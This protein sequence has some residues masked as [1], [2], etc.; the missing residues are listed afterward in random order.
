MESDDQIIESLILNGGLEVYAIDINTGEALYTFT[1]KLEQVNPELH[2]AAKNYF[3]LE[4]INLWEK[5]FL[6]IDLESDDPVVS[7]TDKAL[8]ENERESLDKYSKQSL[9]QVMKATNK[10]K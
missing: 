1:D 7:V 3:Y 6:D 5:G 8:D 10:E 2:A 4:M 9:Y